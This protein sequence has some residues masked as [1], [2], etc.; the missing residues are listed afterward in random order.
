MKLE[1]GYDK[2]EEIKKA[3]VI[4]SGDAIL[5]KLLLG[6]FRKEFL[7]LLYGP[8]K[9]ISKILLS[10]CVNA[11]IILSEGYHKNLDVLRV[12]YVDAVNRFNPYEISKI[13]AQNRLSPRRALENILISRAFTWE[14]VVELLENKIQTLT[15]ID[16]LIIAGIT[17]LFEYKQEHYKG[18]WK[19]IEGI[20]QALSRSKPYIILTAT[21]EKYSKFKP[22]GGK[23]IQHIPSIHV[24][25]NEL[26]RKYEYTLIQHPFLPESTLSRN[27]SPKKKNLA[28]IKNRTLD[29]FF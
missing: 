22:K 12:I 5:D 10:V 6:G 15:H 17:S 20:K 3:K 11:Q 29:E 19:A 28:S 7:H 13:A 1:S 16:V 2:F 27:R 18:L 24:F 21:R 9:T 4:P 26:D 25:I 14:Q 23:V 8:S